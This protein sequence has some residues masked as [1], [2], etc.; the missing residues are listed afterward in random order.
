MSPNRNLL[1]MDTETGGTNPDQHALLTIGLVA[2]GADGNIIAQEEIKVLPEAFECLDSAMKINCIDLDAHNA[3][4]LSREAAF[5]RLKRFI[6]SSFGAGYYNE[7]VLVGH[8]V[9]FD[10]RFVDKLCLEFADALPYSYRSQDTMCMGFIMQ[11]LGLFSA[12]K[13]TLD[14]LMEFYGIQMKQEDRHTAL[15][16]CLATREVHHAMLRHLQLNMLDVPVPYTPTI[17]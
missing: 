5:R 2:Q 11:D 8:N 4:A 12:K 6:I 16:D 13:V 10:R 14:T 3:V 1:Y 7:P 9:T 15:G 17:H